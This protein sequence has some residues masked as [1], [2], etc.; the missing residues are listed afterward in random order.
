M[1]EQDVISVQALRERLAQGLPTTVIDV[2]WVPVDTI[3]GAIHVPLTELEDAPPA[4]D[5]DH[6]LVVFCQHGRGASEY[7]QEVLREHGYPHV[8]RLEGGLDA[9]RAASS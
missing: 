2:R 9:W 7:A 5:P 4:F 6:V 3:P 8:L 1:N